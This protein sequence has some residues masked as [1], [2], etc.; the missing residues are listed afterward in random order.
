MSDAC[1]CT[2]IPFQLTISFRTTFDPHQLCSVCPRVRFPNEANANLYDRGEGHYLGAHFDH[3]GVSG[4]F[5]AT[6]S[7]EGDAC[8]TF[9]REDTGHAVRVELPRRSIQL[10]C[11]TAR[12][13]YTHEIAHSDMHSPRRISITFRMAKLS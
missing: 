4:P 10:V 5:L 9:R 13:S 3:R 11:R 12:Y 6:L 1:K 2:W 8:M 7:L